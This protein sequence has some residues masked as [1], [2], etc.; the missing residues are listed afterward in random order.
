MIQEEKHAAPEEQ[1]QCLGEAGESERS[2]R[3]ILSASPIGICRVRGS[4]FEW[5]NDAMCRM[6]GYPTEALHGKG[7]GLLFEKENERLRAAD[8]LRSEGYVE[9]T[10]RRKDGTMIDILAQAAS[11]DDTSQIITVTDITYRAR[12]ER[13]QAKI[14][15]LESLGVLAGGIAHDFNNILTMILGNITL[16]KIYMETDAPKAK[17]KLSL[18]E[19]SIARAKELTQ[20]LLTFSKGGAPITKVSSIADHLRETARFALTGTGVTCRFDIAEDLFP[21]AI[22]EGQMNQAIGHIAINAHQAMPQGGT[23]LISARNAVFENDSV[24]LAAGRYVHISITDNGIGIPEEHLDRVFDPYFTTKQK[25]S[26]L[27]LA[28]CYS[29]IKNHHGSITVESTLGVGSTFHIYLPVHNVPSLEERRI[30]E[31]MTKVIGGNVLVMDDEEAILDIV[32]DILAY[33]GFTVDFARDGE[34]ALCLYQK[35]VYDVVILDLTVPGGMGGREAMQ[36]LLRIDPMVR[37]IVSSGYSN[38]PIMSDYRQYG[39]K[40][41]IAKPYDLEELGEVLRSVISGN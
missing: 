36:E 23:I 5:V 14:G 18:A 41:V 7:T 3:A 11:I 32:G 29:I 2:L 17:E 22:D 10:L 8:V 12:V 19:Q 6:T 40:N 26:G 31:D 1:E 33:H 38:D 39:F 28:I 4:I 24:N 27:G 13:E 21:V 16:G 30:K 34:E 25:G 37:A 35:T 15:K 9:T 20:Q